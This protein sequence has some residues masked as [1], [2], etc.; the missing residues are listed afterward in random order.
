M[1]ALLFCLKHPPRVQSRCIPRVLEGRHVLDIDETG[2]GKTAAFAL[3]ILHRLSKHPFGVFALV[4]TPTR[5]LAFQLAEQF[6]LTE[7]ISNSKQPSE[8]HPKSHW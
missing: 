2:S 1:F 5:G 3:P 8:W 6:C 7:I 4:V